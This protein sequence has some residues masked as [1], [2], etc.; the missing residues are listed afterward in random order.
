MNDA[1]MEIHHCSIIDV[2]ETVL[3]IELESQDTQGLVPGPHPHKDPAQRSSLNS[4]E[5]EW[6]DKSDSWGQIES[7]L[8]HRFPCRCIYVDA[9]P[10]L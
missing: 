6:L 5:L 7:P 4:I 1:V 9:P 3:S 2:F 10:Q 8:R